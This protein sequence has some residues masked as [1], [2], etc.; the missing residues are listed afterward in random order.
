MVWYIGRGEELERDQPTKITVYST[1]D[2]N[3]RSEDLVFTSCLNVN[4]SA[5]A[6]TYPDSS[7][8]EYIKF[9]SDM[10]CL[11]KAKFRKQRGVDGKIYYRIWYNL[12]LQ[13]VSAGFRFSLEVDGEEMGN[14]EAAFE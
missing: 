11:P 4:D 3:Y 6:P 2:A 5:L 13:K 12:V 9:T 1:L 8:S 10:S 7:V 14:V